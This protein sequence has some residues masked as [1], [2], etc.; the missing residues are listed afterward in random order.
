MEVKLMC[1][2]VSVEIIQPVKF[3]WNRP[4]NKN[5]D[6]LCIKTFR[7]SIFEFDTFYIPQIG[8]KIYLES[9]EIEIEVQDIKR[10]IHHGLHYDTKFIITTKPI[11]V[12]IDWIVFSRLKVYKDFIDGKLDDITLK[13]WLNILEDINKELGKDI[14]NIDDY[15]YLL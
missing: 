6:G 3:R 4:A 15:K 2:L 8:E 1:K 10:I 13:D 12:Y 14:Y 7:C 5:M 9:E 11:N